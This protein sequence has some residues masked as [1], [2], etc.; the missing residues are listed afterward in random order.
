MG[1]GVPRVSASV[2]E[3]QARL[4]QAYTKNPR[5]EVILGRNGGGFG[6]QGPGVDVSTPL[7]AYPRQGQQRPLNHASA[8]P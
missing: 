8:L 7:C 4:P 1:K 3:L 5:Q 2:L 6:S